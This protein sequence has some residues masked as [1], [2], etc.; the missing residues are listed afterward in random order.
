MN[1]SKVVGVR[2]EFFFTRANPWQNIAGYRY[3]AE[4]DDSTS[5]VI[6]SDTFSR[7]ERAYQ[8]ASL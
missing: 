5:K 8:W 4:C 3:M 1:Q 6:L 7:Y 2:A